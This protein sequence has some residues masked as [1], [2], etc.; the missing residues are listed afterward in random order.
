MLL[1]KYNQKL[2]N[3][4]KIND[5]TNNWDIFDVPTNFLDLVG[6]IIPDKEEVSTAP[7]DRSFII[8]TTENS[9]LHL[10]PYYSKGEEAKTNV[11]SNKIIPDTQ[12]LVRPEN[13]VAT[14][15]KDRETTITLKNNTK[16][17]MVHI[18]HSM[19]PT[20]K[21]SDPCKDSLYTWVKSL[22]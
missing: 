7:N 19:D 12:G 20:I 15:S 11:S 17:R 3:K 6:C 21:I 8:R 10:K 22:H 9:A 13:S 18:G 14:S 4:P 1:K 16:L 5:L 2:P